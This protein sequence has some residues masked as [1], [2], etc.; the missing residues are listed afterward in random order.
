MDRCSSLITQYHPIN[1]HPT[2]DQAEVLVSTQVAVWAES[3]V[4]IIKIK[5]ETEVLE[6][7]F[8]ECSHLDVKL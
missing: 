8:R 3:A 6:A 1:S 2:L 7:L 5:E 4:L